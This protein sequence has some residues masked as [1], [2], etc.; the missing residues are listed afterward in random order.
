MEN[1]QSTMSAA[2]KETAKAAK[3]DCGC[4]G[5]THTHDEASEECPCQRHAR[6]KKMIIGGVILVVLG[7]AAYSAWKMGYLDKAITFV[8]TKIKQIG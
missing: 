8:K 1:E 7:I 3:A 5:A 6:M 2:T 4:G